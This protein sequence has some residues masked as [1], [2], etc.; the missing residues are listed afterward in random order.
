MNI[1]L[2]FV[3]GVGSRMENNIPRR[4]FEWN[5]KAIIIQTLEIFE[6]HSDIVVVCKEE[7][8]YYT[9]KLRQKADITK[10]SAVFPGG[11]TALDSQY[12]GLLKIKELYKNKTEDSIVL[13]HDGVRPLVDEDIISSCVSCA[14]INGNAIT[15]TK[16]IETVICINNKEEIMDILDRNYC[17]MAKAPQ[18]IRLDDILNVHKKSIQDGCHT[19]INAAS[20]MKAYG[21][22]LYTVLGKPENIKIT[23]ASDYYMY[24]GIINGGS[25]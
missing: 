13:I 7:L 6:N 25:I 3:G 2:I 15:V 14:K 24:Y 12:N 20:L 11:A 5:E 21:Y 23:T 17:R 16:A 1:A 22:K 9:N 8:I 19:Y 10:V 18:T 4:F